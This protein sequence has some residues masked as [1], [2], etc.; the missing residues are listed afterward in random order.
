MD[1]QT[2]ARRRNNGH[3]PDLPP[4]HLARSLGRQSLHRLG[5]K[6]LRTQLRHMRE[7]ADV[8]SKTGDAEDIHEMRVATRRLR[9]MARVLSPTAAFRGGRV[10]RLRRNLQ[11]LARQLG[12]V[13][14]LDILVVRLDAYEHEAGEASRALRETLRERR[15]EAFQRLRRTLKHSATRRLLRHPRRTA[16]RLTARGKDARRELVRYVAGS[17]IRQ[18]Y[19]ATLRFEDAAR[20]DAEQVATAQLHALRISCKQLRYAIELFSDDDDP[21]AQSLIETLKAVQSHLGELQDSVFAVSLLTDLR[22]DLPHDRTLASFLANQEMRRETLR[23][24]F[25]PLWERLSGE[26]FRRDLAAFIAAM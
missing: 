13:R 2:L 8:V 4:P 24:D 9:T 25:T 21:C 1:S 12:A 22:R 17:A 6:A 3:I 26:A 19:E 5:G 20:E 16:K 10:G 15:A 11:P 18:R 23:R 14:D 7:Y